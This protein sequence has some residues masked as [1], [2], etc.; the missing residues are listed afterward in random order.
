MLVIH[1]TFQPKCSN[2]AQQI[3]R[4][5]FCFCFLLFF[6]GFLWVLNI[7]KW[8]SNDSGPIAILFR[9][10]LELPKFT[11]HRPSLDL[12]T[13]Y[14]LPKYFKKYKKIM[15][16]SGLGLWIKV[17][18]FSFYQISLDSGTRLHFRFWFSWIQACHCILF[19]VLFWDC[20]VFSDWAWV[21]VHLTL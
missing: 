19:Y 15:G 1:G 17:A 6:W 21:C 4:G 11:K 13:P 16:A 18:S 2:R 9:W 10:I 7:P 8:W 20:F 3:T 14:L 12:W 5:C